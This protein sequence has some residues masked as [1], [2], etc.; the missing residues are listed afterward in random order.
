MNRTH[1]FHLLLLLALTLACSIVP[2][3]A[4]N[5]D[6]TATSGAAQATPAKEDAMSSQTATQAAATLAG[7]CF[8]CVESDLEKLPGVTAVISGYT[9]GTEPHP[10]YEQVSSGST[11]HYEAVQVFFDPARVSY[12]Q[13]LDAFLRHIDP[14][15]PDGQFADRGRQYRTAIF[16]HDD[17]QKRVAGQALADL[18]ATGRF[19]RPIVTPILPFTFFTNAESYHQDYWRTH[20]VQYQTYR[21]FSGRDQFLTQ[22]WGKDDQAPTAAK[23]AAATAP[24][25][26]A[27]PAA[28]S[29]PAWKTFVRPPD[30]VLRGQLS[31]IAFEVTRQNGTERP[32]DNP[33]ADNKAPG[34]YVD[35]VSG[36]PLFSSRDKF[37][38]GTGW[39][40]FT[41]PIRPDAVVERVD[42]SL[43]STRTEVRSK[44]ADSHLGHVFPDGPKPTGLRYCMNS[45]ALRFVPAKDL[46]SAG[47]GAYAKDI[48]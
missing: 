9:G 33:Y 14:T 22:V 1:S 19:K 21:N 48:Q 18:G 42:K 34:L 12:R 35:V 29:A 44:V 24:K 37:D 40:S 30:S 6:K 5:P 27:A 28:A 7:G 41:K 20:K 47:Y 2:A 26:A 16:V 13:V 38:S 43:F 11:G 46:E 39:P 8:W 31:P 23:E 3:Q 15:D 4:A 45:A 32:F 36:E 25:D 10:T 17:E